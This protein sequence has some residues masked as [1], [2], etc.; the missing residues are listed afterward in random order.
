MRKHQAI[1]HWMTTLRRKGA[2]L[3]ALVLLTVSPVGCF[4]SGKP[5]E[6]DE[7]VRLE[8]APSARTAKPRPH[9]WSPKRHHDRKR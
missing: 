6:E 2:L 4:D 1:I 8:K 5:A 9:R 3:L 7:Q